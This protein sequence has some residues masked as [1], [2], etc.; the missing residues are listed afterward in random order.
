MSSFLKKMKS[1]KASIEE[2]DKP[3][4][5]DELVIE[6]SSKSEKTRSSK[7]SSTEKETNTSSRKLRRKKL[8]NSRVVSRA[9]SNDAPKLQEMSNKR[10]QEKNVERLL[11]RQKQSTS[12]RQKKEPEFIGSL[13]SAPAQ[14]TQEQLEREP[15]EAIRPVILG[16]IQFVP[17]TGRRNSASKNILTF[18]RAARKIKVDKQIN[19][20]IGSTSFPE[21]PLVAA[22][23]KYNFSL[24]NF[25][26]N[27]LPD[28]IKLYDEA[29]AAFGLSVDDETS[30]TEVLYTLTSEYKKSLLS[31]TSRLDESSDRAI[32]KGPELV[33]Q[34]DERIEGYVSALKSSNLGYDTLVNVDDSDIEV[35][36][37]CMLSLMAKEVMLSYNVQRINSDQDTSNDILVSS[38]WAD[39]L[40][41]VKEDRNALKSPARVLNSVS[42]FTGKT[43]NGIC[44]SSGGNT[45]KS[46]IYNYPFE[47]SKVISPPGVNSRSSSD[48]LESA[49]L[50]ESIYYGVNPTGGVEK[51]YDPYSATA[52][53]FNRASAKISE[54]FD[55]SGLSSPDSFYVKFLQN[56]LSRTVPYAGF[57]ATRNVQ[58]MIAFHAMIEASESRT[59]L[60]N[61]M[62]YLAFRQEKRSNYDGAGSALPGPS[63]FVRT[64][65]RLKSLLRNSGDKNRTQ[66]II[67]NPSKVSISPEP[68]SATG[69]K[70]FVSPERRT[71]ITTT[72][73]AETTDAGTLES[74]Y[75]IT[76][77]QVC[78]MMTNVLLGSFRKNYKGSFPVDTPNIK[79]ANTTTI[80]STLKDLGFGPFDIAINYENSVKKDI[81]KITGVSPEIFPGGRS[82]LNR[83]SESSFAAMFI[84]TYCKLCKL[85]LKPISSIVIGDGMSY[86]SSVQKIKKP[87]S[88]QKQSKFKGSLT[89]SGILKSSL[90]T[91]TLKKPS[92]HRQVTNFNDTTVRSSTEY[93]NV[94]MSL[95]EYLNSDLKDTSDI[96]DSHPTLAAIIESLVEEEEFLSGFAGSLSEFF[97]NVSEKFGK[98][99][100][101]LNTDIDGTTL[102]EKTRTVKMSSDLT[103]LM[104]TYPYSLNLSDMM[105]RGVKLNDKTTGWHGYRLMKNIITD[106]RFV[107][108]AK[109]DVVIVGLPVGFLDSTRYEAAEIE[110]SVGFK[111]QT[112]DDS[113]F[114]VM[115]E[116]VDLTD[117]DVKYKD[118]EFSFSR[119]LF[120]L[121][122]DPWSTWLKVD[123]NF[124]CRKMGLKQ[125]QKEFGRDVVRNHIVDFAMKSYA[126]MQYD[127]DFSEKAFSPKKDVRSDKIE[128]PAA[129]NLDTTTKSFLSSSNLAFDPRRY[130]I[131]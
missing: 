2:V 54:L 127:M 12:R 65:K 72:K 92:T 57:G 55:T 11:K 21:L 23:E 63:T 109:Q 85:I 18:R 120:C 46:Q 33:E 20:N 32:E 22:M 83:Y 40:F 81:K 125:A 56:I 44:F 75:G 111:K 37:K 66:K 62:V 80:K 16:S 114:T 107:K 5:L 123:D 103:K 101:V 129:R 53:G 64:S 96:S 102:L 67:A 73:A 100:S 26:D 39:S 27:L 17:V 90:H 87:T 112:I 4:S 93:K 91:A 117:P 51:Y 9:Q 77:E 108:Q 1:K 76:F 97:L 8:R 50:K 19:V 45:S 116:K 61:L 10:R 71:S 59:V 78:D 118:A 94:M 49:S 89:T 128:V 79:Y 30:A 124:K 28:K 6:E 122:A 43:A 119:K 130:N 86:S 74:I 95:Q 105:Y 48:F 126:D 88:K 115:V 14:F 58:T 84:L 110:E 82:V 104:K 25:R 60:D 7:S 69:T 98:V 113:R 106:S 29:L 36:L 121:G 42:N 35:A 52:S 131:S 38:L 3:V 68:G 31:G 99:Q 47:L 34:K 70:T 24:R 13:R 15:V 41:S